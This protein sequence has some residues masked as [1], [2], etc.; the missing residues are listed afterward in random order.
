VALEYSEPSINAAKEVPTTLRPLITFA[1]AT[2]TT[3]KTTVKTT[4]EDPVDELARRL[5]NVFIQRLEGHGYLRPLSQPVQSSNYSQQ[6][7]RGGY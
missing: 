6:N 3:Q 2:G 4:V 7:Y 1:N 5:E